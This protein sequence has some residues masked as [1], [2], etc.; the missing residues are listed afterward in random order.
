MVLASGTIR[1]FEF[2][3]PEIQAFFEE[4]QRNEKD[5]IGEKTLAF[6]AQRDPA[7]LTAEDRVYVD[8]LPKRGKKPAKDEAD[9]SFFVAHA[10]ELREEPRLAALW[11]R[12]IYGQRVECTDLL[13]GLVQ[14]LRRIYQPEAGRQR[15]LVV[16]GL[17][18]SSASFVLL[19][20]EACRFFATRYRGLAIALGGVVDFR[21]A[22][23]FRYPEF[24]GEIAGFSRRTPR[25]EEQACATTEL[26]RVDRDHRRGGDRAVG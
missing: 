1:P 23:A 9:E 8:D 26:P 11:E 14:S 7:L 22:E 20:D 25:R 18:T 4:A 21:K 3:W 16:E 17:E 12:F 24:A 2:D 10:R 5:S 6:Y 13:D 19:N 15:V